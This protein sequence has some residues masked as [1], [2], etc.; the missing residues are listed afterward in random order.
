PTVATRSPRGQYALYVDD[1]QV[2]AEI[3]GPL[4]VNSGTGS[5]TYTNGQQ[6][7]ISANAPA[8]GRAFDKWVGNTQNVASVSSESTTV[9]MSTFPVTLTALY[10]DTRLVLTNLIYTMSSFESSVFTNGGT[11][12]AKTVD[13]V[14]WRQDQ[15]TPNNTFPW[16]TQVQ[17]N[18]VFNGAQALAIGD[19][20]N[21][22]LA[23]AT[24]TI[25]NAVSYWDGRY[26]TE[27]TNFFGAASILLR[28]SG[29]NQQFKLEGNGSDTN[30]G[31]WY[32]STRYASYALANA[33]GEAVSTVLGQWDRITIGIDLDADTYSFYRNGTWSFSGSLIGNMTNITSWEVDVT[34]NTESR[35]PKGQY[36]FYVDDFQVGAAI[37]GLLTVTRGTGSGSY[38]NGQQVAISAAAI[39]GKTFVAWTG[40]TQY[41]ASASSA[42]TTVTMPDQA[43][44]LTATYADVYY[45][46]TVTSG[47]GGG[48]YTNGHVQAIAAN[49]PAPGHAFSQWTGDTVYLTDSN[50]AST[51]VMMPAQ[52]VSLTATYIV[53]EQYTTNG[54]P[55]S[56]LDLHGLTNHVADDALDQDGDGLK[57]W[58]E[59]I[60]S[61]DPTN[62]T[63]VLRATQATRNVITW[64]AQSNRIYSVYW[65]TNLAH[66]FTALNTNIVPPQ[67]G[68]TNLSPDTRVN[69]YQV[70]VRMQ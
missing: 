52:A 28:G 49:A 30:S 12:A 13:G 66:G 6:V 40:D 41:V 56:W 19:I 61:T 34:P 48:S 58:Q 64:A 45:A 60:A 42:S 2:G 32:N 37:N 63:S 14:L 54:T 7:E 10:K 25:T 16:L 17:T 68:Y 29:A 3:N 22:V 20:T 44:A 9:T 39:G 59:Y 4:T 43:I 15:P 53:T 57:T 70:R 21:R 51:T 67:S 11:V 18:V 50:A 31:G 1:L 27:A 47:T 24:R 55:Y 26:K 65:S 62:A 33:A 8:E 36:A 69:H 46:L 35:S 23:R 38:T 5:G